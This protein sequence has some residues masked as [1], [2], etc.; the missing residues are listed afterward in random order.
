[1]SFQRLT[2]RAGFALAAALLVPDL[3]LAAVPGRLTP[4]VVFRN[5]APPMKL[6]MAL[7]LVAAIAAIVICV[8]KLLPGKRLSGGSAF[9]S[10]LRLGGPVVGIYGASYSGLNM[11]LGLANLPVTPPMNVL[12]HGFAEVMLLI[13]IGF[14][15][16]A[17]AV[18]CNWLIE[19][20]IDRAILAPA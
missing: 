18:V 14:F 4:V 1:M 17:V 3:A 11:T 7:L 19:A 16:G 15:A 8:M 6:A 12:A 5:A 13:G 9:V 20:R 2:R 10:G